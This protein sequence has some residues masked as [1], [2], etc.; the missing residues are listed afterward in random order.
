MKKMRFSSPREALF[1]SKI[2]N[3]LPVLRRSKLL[4]I[5]AA[6]LVLGIPAGIVFQSIPI[7]RP[8][9]AGTDFEMLVVLGGNTRERSDVSYAL[10][11]RHPTPILVTG[12]ED[13]ICNEL[14]RAGIPAS[15][16]L[17][18]P[19]ARNT[20]QNAGFSLPILREQRI[21]S[22][23]IV[24]SWYHTARANACFARI[25]PGIIFTNQSDPV[26]ARYG[27]EEWKLATKERLKCLVYWMTHHLNPW[28]ADK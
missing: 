16:I 7:S 4:T 14:R 13:L 12:D 2:Q 8:N 22:A 20:W 10:W 5:L 1:E 9:D 6:I 15:Q 19:T 28:G 24:T 17:H 3:L 18:E 25:A 21:K 23:V 11:L 26:P 27:A